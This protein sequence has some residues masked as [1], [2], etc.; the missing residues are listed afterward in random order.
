MILVPYKVDIPYD[1]RPVMNWLVVAVIIVVFILQFLTALNRN[2]RIRQQ[3]RVG[4]EVEETEFQDPF[5][6]YILY[7][8]T[9][10]GLLGHMWLHAGFLHVIGNLIFLW[11]FGNAICSKI[12]NYIYLPVYMLLGLTAAVFHQTLVGGPAIGASGAIN[13]IVGMYLVF[14][15]EN[16]ISCLFVFMLPPVWWT[17]IIRT[18]TISSIW[19]VLL[20]FAFD[21]CGLIFGGGLV[22]Y[23]AHVGGFL[24]GFGLATLMLQLKLIGM[25]RYEKSLFQLIRRQ[26]TP[27]LEEQSSDVSFWQRQLSQ[28][29]EQTS[30]KTP[31]VTTRPTPAPLPTLVEQPPP[32]HTPPEAPAEPVKKPKAQLL[33]ITCSCGRKL[34][35]PLAM[36]GKTGICPACNKRVR[37]P[38]K[39]LLRMTCSCGKHFKVPTTMAGKHA[40]CPNC[41]TRFIIPHN[42]GKHRPDGADATPGN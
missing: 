42:R 20:W 8:W 10:E 25:Q 34:K 1:K 28:T 14:F 13:G 18:F 29:A 30:E 38:E 36:A 39:N 35:V 17:P 3:Q 19:M 22:A 2:E 37:I 16:A 15:P 24:A 31:T 32:A 40:I 9:T 7:G 23:W 33:R 5:E 6:P 12:G 26:T 41:K 27:D 4:Q 21:L 11:L